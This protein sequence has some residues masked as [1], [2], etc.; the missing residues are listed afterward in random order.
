[1]DTG[2][3]VATF[4][5]PQHTRPHY[6]ILI[7]APTVPPLYHYT[8]CPVWCSGATEDERI[9]KYMTWRCIQCIMDDSGLILIIKVS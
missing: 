1:M 4:Y 3:L 8:H 6:M 2:V 5:Y 7:V 9:A